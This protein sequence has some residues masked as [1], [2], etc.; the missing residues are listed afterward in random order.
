[1]KQGLSRREFL[2]T[3]SAIPA[4]TCSLPEW[5]LAEESQHT[6]PYLAL[7]RFILPGNDEFPEEKTASLIR[8]S[9]HQALR[10][11]ELPDCSG[12][13]PCPK[14]YRAIAPDLEEG[15]FDSNSGSVAEGWKRWIQSLGAIRRAEFY[16]LP[17]GIIRYEVASERDGK[18]VYRTGQWKQSWTSGKLVAF[19]PIE[20]HVASSAQPYF[21]D[22][23][24]AAFKN[25]T[26]FTEQLSRGVPYWRA[27]LDPA[28]GIDIYGSNGIAVGDIDNDGYDEIYVCQP[29]GLPNRLYKF[30]VD[31]SLAD[32]TAEWQVGILD[33][34]STALFL[35]LRNIGRQDLLVLRGGGPVLFLNDGKRFSLQKDAF[36]FAMAPAGAFTGMAAADFDRDGKLDLYLCCYVYFQSEAQYTYAVPYYDARNGPPNFLFRN[37]LNADGAGFFEDCTADTGMNENNDR[38]S[39]APAWCDFNGDG[40]PDLYVANDFGRKNLYVNENGRFRDRAQ[41][42]GVEDVGPGMSAS[43]FDYDHDG[44][45]DLYVAN[46]WSDAGQRVVRDKNFIPARDEHAKEAYRR[47]T[48]GNSLYRNRGDGTFEETTFQ[49]HVEFGR[50]AWSSGGHDLDNDGEAEIFVT[51]GMLTNT[52][53]VDLMGFFWRQVVARSPVTA[54]P[55][56]AYENGWNAINQFMREEYSWNGHEPNVLHVR[57]GDRYFDFSGVSG[58]DYAEDGRAFAITDFDGDGRPDIVLKSRLGPQVRILQ[59]NCAASN[60][61]IA[62]YLRGTKSNRDA[63]GARI[64][65]DGQTK[66]LDAGSGFLSQHSKRII[67][68]LKDQRVASH[69]RIT[70]PSGAVQEFSD[71]S[72]GKTYFIVEGSSELKAQAFRPH[73][74]LASQPVQADNE[75]RLHDTWFLEPV[76]LPEPQ[77]GPGLFVIEKATPQYEIFR[78]YLFDWRTKLTTPLS[79][80]LN[81]AGHA[82]KIYASLP[83]PEKCQADLAQIG[84]H[85]KLA[86]PFAGEYIGQP[87]RDFFKFGAAYL[88]SGYPAQALPYLEKVLD[89]TP[90]NARVLLLVGQIHSADEHF[91]TAEKYFRQA[92]E[93]DSHSPRAYYG[94]GLALVKLG[95]VDEARDYFKQAITLQPD[96]ADA[97]NDL[98]AL[99]MQQGKIS[100][101][102][103]AFQYGIRVA[104]DEDILYLNLGRTYTRLGQIDKAREV[105]QQLLDRKP[106]DKTA[107]HALEELNGR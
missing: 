65:V 74:S 33:E 31:G 80:L 76:P 68:G 47:H 103:A 46:M 18:L 102:I 85:S 15:I 82:V 40:W 29:G 28:T 69:V 50:W 58:L 17:E 96:Y 78:R 77:D 98:G 73:L 100:D 95:R 91:E 107:R 75:L 48:K 19:S 57:R 25:V 90:G 92:L 87:R 105:M 38:F 99:Y 89:Q 71:L 55:S 49:Q 88:W 54:T 97:I 64:Q 44:K 32:I 1:M 2:A 39:F 59:N 6:P 24:R 66:W 72:A 36:R 52:S 37:K 56:P 61:S 3:A 67:F 83:A 21:R 4:L 14:S 63:I 45:P 84:N 51:C 42:A 94:L 34:T 41:A 7:K 86:L 22:V 13:S 30:N 8:D 12:S 101:A 53:S 62:F 60:S 10:S 16:P 11:G 5:A 70:W 81:E 35:D 43:W 27:R 104:P 20:E 93:A 23:T 79:F 106:D 26:S 9:L